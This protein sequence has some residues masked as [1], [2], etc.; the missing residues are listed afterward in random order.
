MDDHNDSGP[1]S[2]GVVLRVRGRGAL[3]LADGRFVR[4]RALP[5]W[6]AGDEVWVAPAA[7]GGWRST[8][9]RWWIASVSTASIVAGGLLA[10]G[11]AS[12]HVAAVVS[13]DARPSVQLAVNS[14]GRVIAATPIDTSAQRVLGQ[15]NLRGLPVSRA[16][17]LLVQRAA[18]DGYLRPASAQAILVTVAP[19]VYRQQ[20]V[21]SAVTSGVADGRASASAFLAR[22]HVSTPVDVVSAPAAAVPQA[23][24]AGLSVGRWAVYQG[25]TQA[26]LHAQANDFRKSVSDGIEK[27]GIPPSAVAAVLQAYAGQDPTEL[28][29]VVNAARHGASTAQLVRMMHAVS[30]PPSTGG[31]AA[32]KS[33]SAPKPGRGAADKRGLRGGVVPPLGPGVGVGSSASAS[34]ARPTPGGTSA[35]PQSRP[36]RVES[37]LRRLGQLWWHKANKVSGDTSHGDGG[38]AQPGKA[39]TSSKNRQAAAKAKAKAIAKAKAKARK[40]A[41]RAAE[42]AKAAA[43][44]LAR[45]AKRDAAASGLSASAN[46]AAQTGGAASD[47]SSAGSLQISTQERASRR[48][49][50]LPLPANPFWPMLAGPPS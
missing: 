24:R 12:A 26:G 11:V 30:T 6:A 29:A 2:P 22:R 47:A 18:A 19:A 3:V 28:R 7:V 35:P 45:Q 5:G 1:R 46:P 42:K 31:Q 13:I 20:S 23:S 16:I 38:K 39:H 41:R 49:Q 27:A 10:S 34:G 15:V 8:R 14:A 9:L 44:R 4:V 40:A 43:K 50:R 36:G 33:N 37:L 48:S 25:L 17:D 21:P 32:R